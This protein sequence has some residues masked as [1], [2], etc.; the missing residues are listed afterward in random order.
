MQVKRNNIHDTVTCGAVNSL[1]CSDERSGFPA[2]LITYLLESLGQVYLTSLN[3][4]AIM[5]IELCVD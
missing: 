2:L 4:S 3:L 5:A 1:H